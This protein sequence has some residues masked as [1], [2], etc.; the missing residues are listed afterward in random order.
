MIGATPAL[1][2]WDR[3]SRMQPG[4]RQEETAVHAGPLLLWLQPLVRV[5]EEAVC[6]WWHLWVWKPRMARS[7]NFY[8]QRTSRQRQ[9]GDQDGR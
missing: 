1:P 2:E 5:P 8:G 9:K 4:R 7:C 6:S 3:V